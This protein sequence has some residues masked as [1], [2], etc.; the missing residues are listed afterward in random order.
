M[1]RN[2]RIAKSNSNKMESSGK[3]QNILDRSTTEQRIGQMPISSTGAKKKT[4]W[5]C[6]IPLETFAL[7]V[8]NTGTTQLHYVSPEGGTFSEIKLP[9][10][11]TALKSIITSDS[12][13]PR[14]ADFEASVSRK[15]LSVPASK[16]VS[17]FKTDKTDKTDLK[18]IVMDEP[19]GPH[20]TILAAIAYYSS[21]FFTDENI[22]QH[23]KLF[24]ARCLHQSARAWAY[25]RTLE[26]LSAVE[27]ASFV[28][29]LAFYVHEA[30][31][32][33][34]IDPG[35]LALLTQ[36][37]QQCASVLEKGHS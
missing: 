10:L 26:K 34:L 15:Q 37:L 20:V 21:S 9:D 27:I 31:E 6:K 30:E 13:L 5:V 11:P 28:M 1:K 4:I 8:Q 33:E 16:E 25:F 22:N 3:P 35:E 19:E 36:I 24:I 32:Y 18:V 2:S 7:V 29:V 23:L 14:L 12:V 17:V